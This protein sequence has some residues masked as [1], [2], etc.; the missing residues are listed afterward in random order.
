MPDAGTVIAAVARG[1]V[2]LLAAGEKDGWRRSKTLTVPSVEHVERRFGLCGEKSAWY[3]Q[4]WC[5]WRVVSDRGRS[6]VH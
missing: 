4:L 2:K 1:A 5:A 6:G 3:T